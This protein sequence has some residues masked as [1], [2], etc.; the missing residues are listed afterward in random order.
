MILLSFLPFVRP[1]G[2]LML[3]VVALYLIIESQYRYLPLLFTGHLVYGLLGYVYYKDIFWVFNKMTYATWSSAYGSGE[4]LHFIRNLPEIAG[5]AQTLTL[6]AGLA[7]GLILF[8]RYC[9]KQTEAAEKPELFL[10]FGSFCIYFG[11][12]TSFWALGIFNSGGILRVI[13]TVMPLLAL[14]SY[15]GIEYVFAF[16]DKDAIRS[17]LIIATTCL[18]FLYPFS[19]HLYAYHW[20]RDFV[21]KADQY[22]QMELAEWMKATFPDYQNHAFY[23]EAVYLSEVL[24]I[25]W[26]DQQKR[27]RLLGAFPNAAFKSG[28]FIIWD[29]WF[30]VVEGHVS[31]ASLEQNTNL[32]KLKTFQ[33]INYW[34]GTRTTVVF[35]YK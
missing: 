12:H 17:R 15:R 2:L 4:W 5:T 20:N 30:S 31:L 16:I 10:I 19:G 28:D 7:Y 6:A 21:P 34:G 11:A 3:G 35:R 32:E 26:F 14:I 27:K 23:Y 33:R 1:E 29:D 22:A 9:R 13:I 24:Q 25:D 18:L 8:I